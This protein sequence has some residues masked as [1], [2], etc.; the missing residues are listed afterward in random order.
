VRRRTRR[1]QPSRRTARV[2]T[3]GARAPSARQPVG[4]VSRDR[5]RRPARVRAP[6]ASRRTGGRP[7]CFPALGDEDVQRLG[8][9][10]EG[11]HD[12]DHDGVPESR[13]RL[14]DAAAPAARGARTG[15]PQRD[16]R[17]PRA[18]SPPSTDSKSSEPSQVAPLGEAGRVSKPYGGCPNSG[19]LSRMTLLRAESSSG[20]PPTCGNPPQII[21]VSRVRRRALESVHDRRLGLVA[22]RL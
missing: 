19:R 1:R 6:P 20:T 12:V 7:R 14:S 21:G 18:S 15:S 11:A 22:D 4:L 3:L 16:T 17:T 5:S 8:C 2:A 10:S 13:V 9:S